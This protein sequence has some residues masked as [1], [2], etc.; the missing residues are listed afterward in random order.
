[1]RGP[2]R[3]LQLPA[4]AA[5]PHGWSPTFCSACHASGGAG[6]RLSV[7]GAGTVAPTVPTVPPAWAGNEAD[8]EHRALSAVRPDWQGSH[9]LL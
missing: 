6:G 4:R 5:L 9:V 7:G 1:M 8:R 2:C 3:S